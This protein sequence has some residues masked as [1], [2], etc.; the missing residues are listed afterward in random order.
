M[1]ARPHHRRSMASILERWAKDY[2]FDQADV[3]QGDSSRAAQSAPSIPSDALRASG[4]WSPD[5]SP[6]STTP[7]SL[8]A[9]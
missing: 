1:Q 5:P 9:S 3:V 4:T 2:G 8:L 7:P 6:P